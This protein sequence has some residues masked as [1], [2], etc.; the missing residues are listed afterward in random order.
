MPSNRHLPV[1]ILKLIF[2]YV[3]FSTY[4]HAFKVI[5][6]FQNQK[7]NYS[8]SGFIIVMIS[9]GCRYSN[10]VRDSLQEIWMNSYGITGHQTGISIVSANIRAIGW[11]ANYQIYNIKK[12]MRLFQRYKTNMGRAVEQPSSFSLIISNWNRL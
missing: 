10:I 6:M 4:A 3:V 9:P 5:A 2:K 12:F 7:V 8:C 1:K 11:I